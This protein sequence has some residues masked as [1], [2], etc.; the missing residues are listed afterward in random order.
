MS[1]KDIEIWPLLAGLGLFLFGMSMLEEALKLLAGRT[2][3]LFLR[4]H[5]NNPVK[6]VISGT[7]ATAV[8][9]SSSMV[10]LLVMSFAGAGI[11]GLKN[12]IGIL[13][14]ANLGTTATGWIVSLI[15][16]KMDIEALI[17]P[18]FAIGGLG[19]I[20]LKSEKL[21]AVSKLIMGFS[22][23]FLG[24]DYM[25][26]GFAVSAEQ[27]DFAFLREKPSIL[28]LIPGFLLAA[29]IQSSSASM[30]I[31]LSSLAAGV[32]SLN[33]A[34]FL[35][36][37]A[38]LGTTV[39]ALIGTINGNIIKKKIGWSQFF[40]N[41]IG[42][43]LAVAFMKLIVLF[44]ASVLKI[45]DP[46]VI[47]VAFHSAFN[48]INII[49]LLPFIGLFSKL[50]DKIIVSKEDKVS[51]YIQLANTNETDSA[52]EA[53]EAE[54]VHFISNTIEANKS[55]FQGAIL[56]SKRTSS[57]WYKHLKKHETEIAAF[58][59]HLQQHPLTAEQVKSINNIVACVRSGALAVKDIKD[60]K[61]NMLELSNAAEETFF[62]FNKELESHQLNI[63]DAFEGIMTDL[64][65]ASLEEAEKIRA[66]FKDYYQKESERVYQL[67]TAEKKTEIEISSL[68]NMIREI[69]NSNESLTRALVYLLQMDIQ[70]IE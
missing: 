65:H 2:F 19:Y 64:P 59:M 1:F 6:A 68:L 53:L 26:T 28:F 42:V 52:I 24:L 30:M 63:Y 39:T 25:K 66:S 18:F 70:Q 9:Q 43:I 45:S 4:K 21:S 48:V 49:F 16:F 34:L 14:G 3:K 13:L 51:K 20:F 40:I 37:G 36:I 12:G 15:G 31:F 7:L 41:V 47:L 55:F 29:T 57:E 50:I 5:T 69:S 56:D 27:I 60:I 10:S 17:L 32:I 54:T 35:A 23:M 44:I 8:L 33:Q 67:Y 38:D 58:Y 46:L 61:H 22:I 11:I 62:Q